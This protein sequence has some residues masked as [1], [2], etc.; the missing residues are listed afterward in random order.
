MT[1][2]LAEVIRNLPNNWPKSC[3]CSVGSGA[4]SRG[5]PGGLPLAI[6]GLIGSRLTGEGEEAPLFLPALFLPLPFSA[7]GDYEK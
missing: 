2:Q 4:I 7:A 3:S 1:E 5:N 6:F